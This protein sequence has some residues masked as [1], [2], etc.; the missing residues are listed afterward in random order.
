VH[1]QP[2]GGSGKSAVRKT[3]SLPQRAA[4][5][6]SSHQSPALSRPLIAVSEAGNTV[7]TSGLTVESSYSRHLSGASG[8]S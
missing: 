7:I 6:S 3:T 5:Q 8:L 1:M 2:Y 4:S